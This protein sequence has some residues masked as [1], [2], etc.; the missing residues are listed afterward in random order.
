VTGN[1]GGATSYRVT[2]R[3]DAGRVVETSNVFNVY[4]TK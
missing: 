3:D 4:W 2:L 1:R